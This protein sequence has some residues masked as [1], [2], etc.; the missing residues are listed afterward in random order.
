MFEVTYLSASS[1]FLLRADLVTRVGGLRTGKHQLTTQHST[2]SMLARV[3]NG[4]LVVCREER[5][6]GEAGNRLVI[7]A[8]KFRLVIIF[9]VCLKELSGDW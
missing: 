6:G 1:T 5:R 3:S 8:L 9:L 7:Y 4:A 2:L